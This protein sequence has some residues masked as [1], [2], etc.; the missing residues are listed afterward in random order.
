MTDCFSHRRLNFGQIDN[1]GQIYL[2]PAPEN[3]NLDPAK[4]RAEMTH[5][6]SHRPLNLGLIDPLLRG[7][8]WL[9]RFLF[10]QTGFSLLAAASLLVFPSSTN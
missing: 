8:E 5:Y 7:R 4:A 9:L 10:L 3:L 1:F 6:I 2:Y